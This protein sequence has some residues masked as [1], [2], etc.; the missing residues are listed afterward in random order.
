[1]SSPLNYVAPI[2]H[3]GL[4]EADIKKLEKLQKRAL[5]IILGT[6]YIDNKRYYTFENKHLNYNEA[7]EKTGLVSLAMHRE[8]LTGK[9]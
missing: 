9:K 2:W 8:T 4:T 3:S 6:T 5:G 7:L 1:M